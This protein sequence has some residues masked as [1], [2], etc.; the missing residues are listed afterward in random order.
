[1]MY[2]VQFDHCVLKVFHVSL[3]SLS[4]SL[5]FLN[6]ATILQVLEFHLHPLLSLQHGEKKI[7]LHMLSALHSMLQGSSVFLLVLHTVLMHWYQGYLDLSRSY[8]GKTEIKPRKLL[9]DN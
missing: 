1:M 2:L 9:E 8:L 4:H 5:P 3:Q 6:T 7:R